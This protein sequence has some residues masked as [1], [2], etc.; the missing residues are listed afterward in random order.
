MSAD[1]SEHKR[2]EER[3]EKAVRK[4]HSLTGMVGVSRQVR[5]FSSDQRKNLLSRYMLPYL[6]GGASA[7]SA[8]VDARAD[9]GY[10]TELKA[11]MEG[12][13]AAEQTIAEMQAAYAAFEAARSLLSFQKE[14]FKTLPDL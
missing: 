12:F 6:K 4:I 11:L 10:V 14:Q 5:E 13:A 3:I 7:A 9:A 2:N 1:H 8:E